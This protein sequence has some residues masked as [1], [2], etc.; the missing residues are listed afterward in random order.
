MVN[1]DGSQDQHTAQ[2]TEAPP[3]SFPALDATAGAAAMDEAASVVHAGKNLAPPDPAQQA[4]LPTPTVP[5]SGPWTDVSTLPPSC[6]AVA[7][8][9]QIAGYLTLRELG[10]GGMGVVYM[11]R[12]VGLNRL[13]A[14]KMIL[15]GSHA[16]EDDLVRFRTEA[17]AVAGLRHPNIVQIYD[18][19]EQRGLPYFSLEFVEGG[20]LESRL[21]G[22][23]WDAPRSAELVETLARAVHAAHERGIIHRDLKPG[24][25]LLTAEG[26][27]KITDFGLAKRLASPG[28]VASPG[29]QP[30]EAITRTGSIMGTPSY[31]APEQAGGNKTIT[32]GADVYALGAILYEL[33]TGRPPFKGATPLDTVV[34]VLRQEPVPP[35]QLNSKVP[36][37]LETVCLKCLQKEPATRYHSALEL[38]DDLRRFRNREPIHARPVGR[39]EKVSR[40]CRR[41]PVVAGLTAAVA[42]ALV[43]GAV[44]S[45][46]FA[47]KAEH[48]ARQAARR[49]Y[50]AD[51]RL[52]QQAWEQGDV[53]RARELLDR[54]RGDLRGFEWYYWDRLCRA[55][56]P[57]LRGHL[58]QITAVAFSPDGRHLAS[59][60]V[61]ETV[62]IWDLDEGR[63][64]HSLEEHADTVHGLAFSPDGSLLASAS[65]DMTVKVWDP[66]AGHVRQTLTG[67]TAPVRAVAFSQ[68]GRR[69]AAAGE[70]RIVR[71]WS[72]S[73]YELI[74]TLRHQDWVL[75][76]AFSP[77]GSRLASAGRNKTIRIWD[78]STKTVK[79]EI[80][81]AHTWGVSGVAFSPDGKYLA[82]GSWDG[83][84]KLWD[85]GS[86]LPAVRLQE[87]GQKQLILG[88]AF[89]PDGE[90]LAAAGR[91]STAGGA[92]A[93]NVW[94][95]LDG[96]LLHGLPSPGPLRSVAFSPDSKHLAAAG[97]DRV[98]DIWA[99]PGGRK[100]QTLSN[101]AHALTFTQDGRPVGPAGR[102]VLVNVWDPAG[103]QVTLTYRRHEKGVMCVAFSP[104][105]RRLASMDWAPVLDLWDL[106]GGHTSLPKPGLESV[107]S[108]VFDPHDQWFA[109]A[110]HAGNIHLL[111][112]AGNPLRTLNA[113]HPRPVRGLTVSADGRWLAAARE[114]GKIRIWDVAAGR[115][116]HTLGG[117]VGPVT[118]VAFSRDGRL[119]SAGEDR[120]VRIW[121]PASEREL[122]QLAGH[123]SA[124]TGVAWRPDGRALASSSA[125]RTVRIWDAADGHEMYTLKGHSL[126]VT[127]VAYSPDGRRLASAS[128]D[129]TVKLWE[130][131]DGQELLTLRGHADGITGLAFSPDGRLLVSASKDATVKVW[132]GTPTE[133]ASP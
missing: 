115:E 1:A 96:R 23:P 53:G 103:G 122:L 24:N 85:A 106:D 7:V 60:G 88:V 80:G 56:L 25:V 67:P 39:V 9:A 29:R 62:K 10:R 12:Q 14:L 128:D 70:D 43:A 34:Q 117:H 45:T 119:A 32:P 73:G 61:D 109:L 15:A 99:I 81:D 95:V 83:S 76:V 102:E 36:R 3:E 46:F 55:G 41:N 105:G 123:G 71:V 120:T 58:W 68:D 110:G 20:S 75:G 82:S 107:R 126:G 5:G 50:I 8:Q 40:W 92:S 13:V 4:T 47:L 94:R 21:D 38:A 37:D 22:T 64:M 91:N 6:G 78:L 86:G 66:A 129:R 49:L 101:E 72:V 133:E 131:A 31:M 44:M 65:A 54:E 18:I 26:T 98:V 74:A 90:Y 27:P 57:A 100:T 11:A 77:D 116:V 114:D 19:S 2:D 113:E 52:V 111:G 125:D 87:P 17:E 112:P 51:L 63:V 127:A 79:R 124:V 28:Q 93:V 108:L 89:S 121:D 48:R 35:A 132:N 59:A 69:L 33:L 30:G 130:A 97:E 16:G 104:D 84:V 118:A 42:L